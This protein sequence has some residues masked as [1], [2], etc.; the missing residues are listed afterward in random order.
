MT[1]AVMGVGKLGSMASRL[2][3]SVIIVAEGEFHTCTYYS[4]CGHL[5]CMHKYC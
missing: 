3:I 1:P 5:P 4:E 2:A